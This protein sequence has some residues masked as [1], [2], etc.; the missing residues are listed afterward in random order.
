MLKVNNIHKNFV[1]SQLN[2]TLRLKYQSGAGGNPEII[3]QGV[4]SFRI[5]EG[6][7]GGRTNLT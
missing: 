6:R 5:F 3:S 4:G 1:K 7:R 2:I